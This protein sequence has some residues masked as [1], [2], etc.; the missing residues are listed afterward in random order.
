[1]TVSLIIST[2]NWPD[3]LVL[4]LKSVLRQTV[5]PAEV[6]IADDGSTRETADVVE[7]FKKQSPVPVKHI[8]HEDKGFRLAEIR[9][10]AIVNSCGDYI[11]QIDGDIILDKNFIKDHMLV[12]E[13]GCFIRGTRAKLDK[14]LSEALCKSGDIESLTP[15]S[16]G[17]IQRNNALRLPFLSRSAIR[18]SDSGSRV[19]GCNMAFW[20]DDLIAVNGYNNALVGWGH[21]DEDLSWRLINLGLKKKIIKLLAVEYHIHHKLA[22]RSQEDTHKDELMC[23]ETN[24]TVRAAN[25]ISE[26]DNV[27]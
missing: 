23:V 17:V 19:K 26:L 10:K 22:S 7:W 18:K 27:E 24:K 13:A 12:A 8:W 14:E 1:M 4:C 6:V 5:Q 16:K 21:E 9:N 15:F 20:K 11:I 3:A 2:Y 25:G